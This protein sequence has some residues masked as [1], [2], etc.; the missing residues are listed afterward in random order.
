MVIFIWTTKVCLLKL[1]KMSI[2]VTDVCSQ[3]LYVTL[4]AQVVDLRW[5]HLVDDLHQT[6]TVC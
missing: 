4:S 6:C 3:Y 1:R 5:L 2:A